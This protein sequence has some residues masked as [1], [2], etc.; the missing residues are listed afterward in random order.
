MEKT[1][2]KLASLR[3]HV[4]KGELVEAAKIGAAAQRALSAHHGHC[5][6]TWRLRDGVFEFEESANLEREKRMEGKYVVATTEKGFDAPEAVRTYKELTE[7]ERGFR[8]L[9]DVLAVRPIYHRVATRVKAHIFVAAL[10]LLL[11]R[12][13]ERRLKAAGSDLSTPAAMEALATVRLVTFRLPGQGSRRG[14]SSGSPRAREV[15]KSRGSPISSLPSPKGSRR[16]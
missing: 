11:D 14:A 9:K 15:L 5:Y 6:Y 16:R 3:Q 8:H 13:P 10:A 1:R 12:L 7:V 4:A 2:E